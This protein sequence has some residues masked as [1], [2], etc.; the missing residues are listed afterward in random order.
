MPGLSDRKV[1]IV[2]YLVESAPDKIVGNLHEA[3]ATTSGDTPLAEVR[4]LV[5][6][7]VADRRLRNAILSPVVPLFVG[8]GSDRSK[9]VFPAKVLGLIWRGLRA[10]AAAEVD[11]AERALVDFR[12]G[13][14]GPEPL[15]LLVNLA[16]EGLAVRAQRDFKAAAELADLGRQGGADLLVACLALVPVT[17][18]ASL[19]L[20]D[21][22]NR[23][24]DESSAAARLAYKDAVAIA[25][26]AGPRF[27]EMLAAQLPEPWMILRIVSAVMDHPDEH[28]LAASELSIFAQRVMDQIDANLGRVVKFDLS[29]G[30]QGG[31]DAGTTVEL[32]TLQIAEI[33][34][35]VELSRDGGWGGRVQKQ[36]KALASVVEGRFRECEKVIGLALPSHS[37]RVARMQKSVP[38]LVGEPDPMAVT[39]ALTLLTFV[40]AVR[41]SANYGGFA[42]ARSK[43]VEKIGETVDDYVEE[44]LALLREGIV[45]DPECGRAFLSVAADCATLLRDARS[46]DVIRRRAVAALGAVATDPVAAVA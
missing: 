4:R 31:R 46:G 42:S 7:E 32:I 1:E 34:S 37:V 26:D 6:S 2:R 15:D 14:T 17:R 30:P 16:S 5:E 38:R 12:P 39:R 33:E 25:D 22:T 40:E 35:N 28:Y 13:E 11:R 45:E 43:M 19:K 8:D 24:T 27:F 41:S 36:K 3:L 18:E 21:W 10:V 9:L 29:S 44:S 23:T 20:P